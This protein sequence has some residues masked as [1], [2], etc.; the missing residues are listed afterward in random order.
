MKKEHATRQFAAPPIDSY[1]ITPELTLF[2][3]TTD[4]L[5]EGASLDVLL[6][7]HLEIADPAIRNELTQAVQCVLSGETHQIEERVPVE[8]NGYP[9]DLSIQIAALP[10]QGSVNAL[11]SVRDVR[12]AEEAIQ[13]AQISEEMFN[14]TME[15]APIGEAL[16]SPEG[17]WL[18][19]NKAVCAITGYPEEELLV[20]DFQT[21]THPDD[22]DKDVELVGQMLR[23]EIDTYHMEKRYIRKDGTPIWI[24]LSVSLVWNAD[25]TPRH[26]IS[27]IQDID[28][29]KR[30][31]EERRISKER[32][33]LALRGGEL[34]TW[35]WDVR[36]G[37]VNFDQ[38]WAGMLGYKAS[39]LAP[40][41]STWEK[42]VHPDDM[43]TTRAVLTP[44]LEGKTESY[45]AELRMRHKDGSWVWILTKGKVITRDEQGAPLRVCGTH[46]DITAQKNAQVVMEQFARELERSNK[47]LEDFAY[48]ASHDLKEPLRGISNYANFILEDYESQLDEE[49][50][51]KLHTLVRL[52]EA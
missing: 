15:N 12:E 2:G 10:R 46:L 47:E 52:C 29:R 33:E 48:I 50:V 21:L 35:D 23:K 16:V 27:Q 22:L 39:D 1:I 18:R 45:E 42:A 41:F 49:G 36:T 38:R 44:H 4:G 24:L 40:D 13:A 5:S 26:F 17:T 30:A 51:S 28:A 19:V 8:T 31:D 6:S 37:T 43:A 9:C 32:L 3:T 11:I 34:G 20:T 25:G 14:L 7:D